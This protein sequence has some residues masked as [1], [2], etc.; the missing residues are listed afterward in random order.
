MK[1]KRELFVLLYSVGAERV[2]KT[3][4][5]KIEETLLAGYRS[6]LL[7]RNSSFVHRRLRK[8][9]LCLCF[10]DCSLPNDLM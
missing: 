2:S 8:T 4:L 6:S 5:E 3:H 7:D 10:P 1:L 9:A